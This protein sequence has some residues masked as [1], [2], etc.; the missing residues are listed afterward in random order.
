M[1]KLFV[2]LLL[3]FVSLCLANPQDENVEVKIEDDQR[4]SSP[5][6]ADHTRP[7]SKRAPD[8]N[9][10]KKRAFSSPE[11]RELHRIVDGESS[12]EKQERTMKIFACTSMMQIQQMKDKKQIA[13]IA[14][15]HS[16]MDARLV[17]A[18]V[19][20]MMLDKCYH[21]ITLLEAGTVCPSSWIEND[22]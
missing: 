6:P 3:V 14:K 13:D 2:L 20:A 16:G 12:D 15:V 21:K 17:F 8:S 22:V 19:A 1:S 11:E 10:Y 7:P 4:E 5:P 18:K 9:Y